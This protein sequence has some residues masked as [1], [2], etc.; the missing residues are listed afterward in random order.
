MLADAKGGMRAVER[1]PC[2]PGSKMMWYALRSMPVADREAYRRELPCVTEAAEVL[3]G[4]AYELET[5]FAPLKGNLC[6]PTGG[7]GGPPEV[8]LTCYPPGTAYRDHMDSFGPKD[9]PR[10]VSLVLYAN[11]KWEEADGGRLKWWPNPGG[12][13]APPAAHDA[14]PEPEYFEP[15]GGQLALMWSRGT[16]HEIEPVLRKDRYAIVVWLWARDECEIVSGAG[17]R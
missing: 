9:N 8:T 13:L 12:P 5:A 16:R 1:S 14:A 4:L 3:Q 2:N 17:G 11:P 6:V 7:G 10:L 15:R